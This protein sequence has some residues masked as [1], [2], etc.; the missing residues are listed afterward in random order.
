MTAYLHSVDG[1]NGRLFNGGMG[2]IDTS[3][4]VRVSTNA[5]RNPPTDVSDRAYFRRVL[6]TGRPY[7]SGGLIGRTIGAPVIVVAVPT[8]DPGGRI[9]GVLVGSVRL[10]SV[11]TKRSALDLGYE[12]LEIVDRNGKELLS[13]L[14]P[15]ENPALLKQMRRS[16]AGVVTRMHGLAGRGNHVVAFA[17]AGCRRG[18]S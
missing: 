13:G 17:S 6:A 1:Q 10:A 18:P 12:G 14:A 5:Q 16:P 7:V 11:R 9:S 8:R 3:G 15:V 4:I 2:W